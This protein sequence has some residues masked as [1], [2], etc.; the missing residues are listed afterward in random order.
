MANFRLQITSVGRGARRRAIA[1]AAYPAAHA[2]ILLPSRLQQSPAADWARD[3][4]MLWRAAEQAES[5]RGGR[6][7]REFQMSLP[8]ELPAQHRLELA[9]AFS[10]QI[11]ERYAVAVDLAVHDPPASSEPRQFHA[12]LL[13]TARQVRS[14]GL[15]AKTALGM[16]S[17]ERLHL[18]LPSESHEFTEMR[19][20]WAALTNEAL[21]EAGFDMWVQGRTESAEASIAERPSLHIRRAGVRRLEEI[22]REASRTW[23]QL[24]SAGAEQT[25]ALA[26][27]VHDS[28]AQG[29]VA[30]DTDA[31]TRTRNRGRDD[32]YLP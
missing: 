31:Q 24:R 4:S 8:A 15:G 21:R 10:R 18:G 12:H 19:A 6:L 7:A 30:P 28:A 26:A 1:A 16:H 14:A 23:L 13:A 9:R 20:Q 3:R 17:R 32:D 5:R 27:A 11:A 25:G 29:A 2:E 22:R